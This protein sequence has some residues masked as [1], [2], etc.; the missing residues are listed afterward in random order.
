MHEYVK[1][2]IAARE[3]R[4]LIE[5]SRD[6]MP[7]DCVI[8]DQEGRT[9]FPKQGSPTALVYLVYCAGRLKF[10][11]E[12]EFSLL[13]VVTPEQLNQSVDRAAQ[14][15]YFHAEKARLQSPNPFQT[16][17]HTALRVRPSTSRPSSLAP[18]DWKSFRAIRKFTRRC[19]RRIKL[20]SAKRDTSASQ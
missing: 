19:L 11:Y 18:V 16:S 4:L 10:T 2:A 20:R 5:L 15:M 1:P 6:A 7:Q 8:W 3:L 13:H 12:M 17:D 14:R 9:V